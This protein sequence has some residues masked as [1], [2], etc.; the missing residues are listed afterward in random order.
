MNINFPK[1]T[2]PGAQVDSQP[3]Q[4]TRSGK[5]AQ[6][7]ATS[8]NQQVGSDSQVSLSDTNVRFLKAQLANLP[9]VRQDRVQSLQQAIHN[10][11][12]KVSSKEL[13]DAIHSDL[14]G[15]EGAGS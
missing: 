5:S 14:F 2:S 3:V 8:G 7:A 11:T 15:S 10:G 6:V 9:S 1:S 13:A 4:A 12:F